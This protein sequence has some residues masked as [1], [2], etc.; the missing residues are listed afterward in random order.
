MEKRAVLIAMGSRIEDLAVQIKERYEEQGYK[1]Y[2]SEAINQEQIEAEIKEIEKEDIK[3]LY[4][5][6][7]P[8]PLKEMSIFEANFLPEMRKRLREGLEN[9]AFWVQ[10]LST[11]ARRTGVKSSMIVLMHVPSVVPD[12][13]YS[14]CCVPEAALGNL[15]RVAVMDNWKDADV[16]INLLTYGWRAEDSEEMMWLEEMETMYGEAKAPIREA[17]SDKEIADACVATGQLSGLN[18]NDLFVDHGYTI[19]RTIRQR[20]AGT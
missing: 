2:R 17:V 4:C 9:G 20:K 14:Y 10:Q 16:R 5:I 3:K 13:K 1:V 19:S 12:V 6:Y 8:L 11:Y 15:V 7:I 18:G